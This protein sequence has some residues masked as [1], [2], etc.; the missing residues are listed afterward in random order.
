MHLLKYVDTDKTNKTQS[1]FFVTGLT[2][3]NV[4]FFLT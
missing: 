4:E 2:E 1:V 3:S